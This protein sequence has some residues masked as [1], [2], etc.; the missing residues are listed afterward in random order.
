MRVLVAGRSGQVANALARGAAKRD[1]DIICLGR[2]GLDITDDHTIA[3]AL[4]EHKPDV[5]INAAAYTAVDRAEGDSKAA[6]AVNANGPELLAKATAGRGIP[7]LHVSTDYV[8]SGSKTTAYV[9]DDPTAPAGIYGKSK[10]AGEEAVR[11]TNARHVIVRTAWV[12]DVTGS[13]FPKTMLRLAVQRDEVSIISD[14]RGN[15]TD[16][17]E[18]ANALIAAAKKVHE[19]PQDAEW[20]TFHF[21]GPAS[22]NWADFARL[23]FAVSARHGGP[24]ARVL[25]ITTDDYPTAAKRP[26]NSMLDSSQFH[27]RFGYQAIALEQSL[28]R[29]MPQWLESLKGGA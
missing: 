8:F 19:R 28:E 23:I 13:N 9:E 6:F 22:M 4:D 10:L 21:S 14:Q 24:V 26:A 27:A 12:F 11:K 16:A 15:P 18:I 17:R 20:G 3:S 29:C 2:P 7:L 5:V 1:G 25:D